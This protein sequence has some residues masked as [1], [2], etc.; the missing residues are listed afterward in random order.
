MT[1]N[2]AAIRV[3]GL[4]KVFKLYSRPFNIFIEWLT[5]KPRHQECVALSDISFDVKKGEVVGVIGR[6]GAGKSTLLKIL[7][8]TLDKTAGTVEVRG[9]ISAILELGAGFHPEYTGRENIYLGGMCLGMGRQEIDRKIQDI[10][11]F[12]ELES[13]IDQPFRT[14]SSGMQARLTFSVAISVEP[15]IFIV[16]EALA[17]G[18]VFFV[19]KC[20]DRITQICR[21]GATVFFVS[22]S[23]SLVE[24]LC[25][26]VIWLDH[27]KII[28][29]GSAREIVKLYETQALRQ[30]QEQLRIQAGTSMPA[31]RGAAPAPSE[32]IV[33]FNTGKIRLTKFELLNAAFEPSYMFVQGE[34]IIIRLHYECLEPISEEEKIVPVINIYKQGFAIAGWVA[35]E[36]GLAYRKLSGSGYFECVYPDHC[37]GEGDY[38]VSAGF[39]RD[40]PDQKGED[41]YSY[42]WKSFHF[43]VKRKRQ[44]PYAYLVEPHVQWRVCPLEKAGSLENPENTR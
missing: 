22:H 5:G 11:A 19:N 26:R 40:I 44:R 35:S 38:I 25:D 41:L 4:S 34:D 31:L 36:W 39:V 30:Q 8:G 7:A 23:A 29:I 10:I 28:Q 16:D 33:A 43:Q 6:N 17:T 21:S 18:D 15:E 37:L 2:D 13:V 9:K 3:T 24:R 1:N 14:Y 27:G 20:L 32:E 12:S 42:Y